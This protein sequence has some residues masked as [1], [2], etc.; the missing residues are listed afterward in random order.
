MRAL[1]I[2][3]NRI[4]FRLLLKVCFLLNSIQFVFP[5]DTRLDPRSI[6]E[7]IDFERSKLFNG[8]FNVVGNSKQTSYESPS[9][10]NEGKLRG[11]MAFDIVSGSF[12]IDRLETVG[13]RNERVRSFYASSEGSA[14]Y[15]SNQGVSRASLFI[16]KTSSPPKPGSFCFVDVRKIGFT[17]RENLFCGSYEGSDDFFIFKGE[18]AQEI[19]I[20]EENDSI[21]KLTHKNFAETH[22]LWINKKEGYTP[23][24]HLS[25]AHTGDRYTEVKTSWIQ[26]GQ[27]W[28][29]KS[30]HMSALTPYIPPN[31]EPKEEN[32]AKNKFAVDLAFTWNYANDKSKDLVLD[33]KK[34]DLPEESMVFDNRSGHQKFVYVFGRQMPPTLLTSPTESPNYLRWL[35]LVSVVVIV[36]ICCWLAKSTKIGLHK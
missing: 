13:E 9:K 4:V 21:L 17:A 16:D 14:Y 11:E 31:V 19:Q 18:M 36:G 24:R 28:V 7:K 6:K 12:L 20:F 25:K 10:E 32:I 27:V 1:E 35:G 29:P 5:D 15:F 33:Y 23:I 22:S 3:K 2:M 8:S 26:I 34:F 30:M